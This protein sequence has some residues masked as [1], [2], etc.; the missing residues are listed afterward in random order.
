MVLKDE[1]ENY[2]EANSYLQVT[3]DFIRITNVDVG[4]YDTSSL[5]ICIEYF[6]GFYGRE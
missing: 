2:K 3:K 5:N 1:S 6:K 4:V